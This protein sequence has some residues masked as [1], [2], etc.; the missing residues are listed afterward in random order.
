ME[1]NPIFEQELRV[2]LSETDARGAASLPSIINYFQDVCT[3]QSY[4]VGV[5]TDEVVRTGHGWVLTHWHVVIDRYPALDER[6]TV[7]TF[8]SRLRGPMASRCFYMTSA[9]ETI[10]RAD[11]TWMFLDLATGHPMRP[12]A[13]FIDPYGV[14]EALELPPAPR[15]VPLADDAEPREPLRVARHD[16]DVNGHMNNAQYVLIALDEA[17]DGLQPSEVIVDYHRAAVEGDL[18]HPAV[19]TV[20]G[21]TSVALTADDGGLFCA[22]GFR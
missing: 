22:V 19:G 2:R 10:A 14:S 16:I 5:G 3:F 7:G 17:E 15:R 1:P 4:E 6:V 18:V 12:E 13:R 8:C 21:Y 11:S 9:G 20:G